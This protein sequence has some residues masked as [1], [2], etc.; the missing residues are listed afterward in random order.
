MVSNFAAH[1]AQ[2][3]R[4]TNAGR[5]RSW[6][7]QARRGELKYALALCL[8]YLRPGY[9]LGAAAMIAMPLFSAGNPDQLPGAPL[10]GI[11]R[12]LLPVFP[13]FL[14]LAVWALRRPR[15]VHL[16][17]ITLWVS[18]LLIWVRTFIHGHWVA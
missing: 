15:W 5:V 13:C 1:P 18:W 10:M 7:F 4:L 16:A 8:R 6:R 14:A 3:V 17:I 11:T 12:Y 9:T 2:T